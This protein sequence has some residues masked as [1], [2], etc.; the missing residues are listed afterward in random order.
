LS[1]DLYRLVIKIFDLKWPLIEIPSSAVYA[2]LPFF[3]WTWTW[4]MMDQCSVALYVHISPMFVESYRCCF[5]NMLWQIDTLWW[6]KKFLWMFSLTLDL[7]SFILCPLGM[8]NVGACWKNI[9]ALTFSFPVS[10]LYTLCTSEVKELL[11]PWTCIC[12]RYH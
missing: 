6:L 8:L 11:S 7:K 1:D 3:I 5:N 9:D 12:Q 2:P 4:M 10:I